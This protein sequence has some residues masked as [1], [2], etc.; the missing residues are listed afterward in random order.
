MSKIRLFIHAVKV[1]GHD[2]RVLAHLI[3]PVL[4][5][6]FSTPESTLAT[7]GTFSVVGSWVVWIKHRR[8][9]KQETPVPGKSTRKQQ[10]D[11]AEAAV[12]AARRG[13]LPAKPGKSCKVSV[14]PNSR[15]RWKNGGWEKP[16]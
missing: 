1:A 14:K 2:I 9:A 16:G 11:L 8:K 12:W 4:H 15:P 7:L 5:W 6:M 13:L 10:E 3:W